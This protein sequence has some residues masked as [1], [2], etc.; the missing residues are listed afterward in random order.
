MTTDQ[1]DGDAPKGEID[2][3][4]TRK[5][6]APT[7]DEPPA[8][9]SHLSLET[10]PVGFPDDGPVARTVRE[11]DRWIGLV[12]QAALVAVFA[13]VVL[14]ASYTALHDKLAQMHLSWGP[15]GHVGR[16]WHYI[17][18]GGTFVVA[19]GAA[20]FCTQQQRHLAMD[21]VSRRL[22]PRGR[23]LLG[24]SLK[25]IVIAAAVFLLRTGLTVAEADIV[26][27]SESLDFWGIHIIDADIVM[28]V[29]IG[30]ALIIVHCVLHA[31][32]EAEYLVN[33]KL[34]PERTR[35]GH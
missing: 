22:S 17:V 18:R 32:I 16:W 30:A 14:V 29:P 4:P 19:M 9:E 1:P 13:T 35:S 21:L 27:G 25:L 7:L 23:L 2:V 6:E 26:G 11:I 20:A 12:E 8:R 5:H 10:I 15:E 34:P 3:P 31:V 28:M 33:G 24:F